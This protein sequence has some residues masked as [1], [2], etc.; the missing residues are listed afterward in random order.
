MVNKVYA[1]LKRMFFAYGPGIVKDNL[2]IHF[3]MADEPLV[4]PQDD[5]AIVAH[6]VRPHLAEAKVKAI[7]VA[8]GNLLIILKQT[9]GIRI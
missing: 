9:R 3:S 2:A 8:N 7:H 4:L 5:A 6:L 1:H